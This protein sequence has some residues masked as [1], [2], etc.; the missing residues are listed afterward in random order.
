MDNDGNREQ[1]FWIIAC[2][3][4]VTI[5]GAFR[6]AATSGP[7]SADALPPQEPSQP[8]LPVTDAVPRPSERPN[9]E[10]AELAYSTVFECRTEGQRVFSDRRCGPNVEVRAIGVPNRMDAQDTSILSTP[11]AVLA[12]SQYERRDA[13]DVP[14]TGGNQGECQALEQEKN[15][16]D[17][18]MRSGYTSQEGEW[19]RERLRAIAA[20]YYDLRCRHF[21]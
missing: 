17:A 3:L 10:K 1:W 9:P 21:H 13:T 8:A 11:E 5:V 20:R 4:V 6:V 7:H 12:R 18:R 15:S 19:Y 2:I 16:I 14:A